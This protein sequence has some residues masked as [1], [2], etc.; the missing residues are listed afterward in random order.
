MSSAVSD[1]AAGSS[2]FFRLVHRRKSGRSSPATRAEAR[3]ALAARILSD[4]ADDLPDDD[5][6]DDL[7]DCIDLYRQGSKPRCEE[8]EY[9]RALQEARDHI[10]YGY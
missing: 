7:D 8:A 1:S 4:L 5:L 3:D 2:G 9:L 10:E 6:L